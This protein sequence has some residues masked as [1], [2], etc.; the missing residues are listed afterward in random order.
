[1]SNNEKAKIAKKQCEETAE[2]YYRFR[3]KGV[4][5]NDLIE[6]PAMKKLIGDVKGKKVLDAGCGFGFYSIYCAKQGADIT[7]IDISEKMIRL[8]RTEAEKENVTIDFQ[9]QDA[10]ASHGFG[11]EYFDMVISSVALGIGIQDFFGQ[12]AAVLKPGG[13]LCF[14]EVHPMLGGGEKTGEKE[15]TAR[16]VDHYFDRGF[17]KVKNA[18]S[19]VDPSDEDYEWTWEHFTLQDYFEAM[20]K[21]G[22]LIETLLEPEPDPQVA[23]Q[24]PNQFYGAYNYPIFFLIRA[25]KQ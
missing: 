17:R 5:A 6:I 14:S 9:V 12:M 11:P 2:I 15:Q 8:A 23:K 21:A 18:F 24:V 16:R 3:K 10:T 1:M 25:I 4:T 20:R 22:F 7:A 19:K 13:I